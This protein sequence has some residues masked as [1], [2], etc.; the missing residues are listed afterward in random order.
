MW[1]HCLYKSVPTNALAQYPTHGKY[2]F[3][4]N[5]DYSC[6]CKN[7]ANLNI[8]IRNYCFSSYSLCSQPALL[9]V[10]LMSSHLLCSPFSSCLTSSPHIKEALWPGPACHTFRIVDLEVMILFFILVSITVL[11]PPLVNCWIQVP[12]A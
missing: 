1:I 12:S 5:F 10:P 2:S 11:S 3:T 6:Y 7:K 9:N 4:V 8:G